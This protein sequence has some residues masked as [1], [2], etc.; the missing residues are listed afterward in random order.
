MSGGGHALGSGSGRVLG[1]VLDGVAAIV[2]FAL[3]ALTCVDVV[4][5]EI[6]NVPLPAT[7]LTRIAMGII[8]FSA[9]PSTTLREQHVCVDLLDTI[10]PGRI[11]NAKQ[12][13]ICLL[14]AVLLGLACWQV[15]LRAEE[16]WFFNDQSEFLRV[17]MWPVYGYL[18]VMLGLATLA[19]LVVAIR[20]TRDEGALSPG[21][22]GDRGGSGAPSQFS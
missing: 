8:V 7:D 4:S 13:F 15:G 19:M 20:Y 21:W 14:S 12:G 2:L 6:F 9:L 17:Q 22:S 16:A 1:G 11:V 18:S 10:T 3:M 5:R